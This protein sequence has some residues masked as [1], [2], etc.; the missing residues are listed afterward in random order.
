MFSLGSMFILWVFDVERL[1][2]AASL[3]DISAHP[4]M[5]PNGAMSFP[6][7]PNPSM[8]LNL[9][10]HTKSIYVFE[11]K[12]S[13]VK[14]YGSS[15]CLSVAPFDKMKPCRSCCYLLQSHDGLIYDQLHLSIHVDDL[16]QACDVC[17]KQILRIREN[18]ESSQRISISA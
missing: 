18:S 7:T 15:S 4:A 10:K 17:L 6:N 12:S 14:L 2:L 13:R 3:R 16:W 8:C 11:L 5:P 1:S 9:S